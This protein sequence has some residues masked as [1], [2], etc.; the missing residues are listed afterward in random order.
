MISG[1]QVVKDQQKDHPRDG[2]TEEDLWKAGVIK[3]LKTDRKTKNSTEWHC[4]RQSSGIYGW[5][6]LQ[7]KELI[8]GSI[9][10]SAYDRYCA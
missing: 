5:K 4:R 10:E 6:Q 8:R 9:H 1:S 2:W 7:G 3:F